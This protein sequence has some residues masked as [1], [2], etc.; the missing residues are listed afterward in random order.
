MA[1]KIKTLKK[2]KAKVVGQNGNVFNLI[3]ICQ[4]ALKDA[5]QG[6]KSIEMRERVFAAKSYD[7]ALVIMSDYCILV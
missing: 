7:E 3:G 5:N 2:P 4:R 1:T 6:D